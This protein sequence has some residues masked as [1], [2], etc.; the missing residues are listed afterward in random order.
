MLNNLPPG[1]TDITLGLND[2][3]Y[4]VN[5]VLSWSMITNILNFDY[6]QSKKPYNERHY[7]WPVISEI[8]DQIEEDGILADLKGGE[9][10]NGAKLVRHKNDDEED[11]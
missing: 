6:E 3:E 11:Y 5:I 8:I 10:N 2:A 7:I 9:L 1:I 4:S